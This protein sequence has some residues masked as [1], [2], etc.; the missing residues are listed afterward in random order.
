MYCEG[1]ENCGEGVW[2]VF[3]ATGSVET[4]VSEVTGRYDAGGTKEYVAWRGKL[5]RATASV[6]A[7]PSL[8][9]GSGRSRE[10]A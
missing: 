8:T 4:V 6:V 3:G 2:T 9:S 5:A 1:A 10:I 7:S